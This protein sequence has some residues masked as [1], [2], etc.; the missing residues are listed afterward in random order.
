MLSFFLGGRLVRNRGK[1]LT[2]VAMLVIGLLVYAIPTLITPAGSAHV[3]AFITLDGTDVLAVTLENNVTVYRDSW[4][5]PHIYANSTSDAYVALGYCMAQDRIFE[6]DLIR[7]YTGGRLS[8]IFGPD[9]LP[10]DIAARTMGFYKIA[11][12]WCV[13]T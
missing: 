3:G 8:E 4:G 13:R 11:V 9:F 12:G 2:L 6:M 7:R 5:V 10:T 1:S